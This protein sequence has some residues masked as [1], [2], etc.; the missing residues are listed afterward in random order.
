MSILFD[1]ILRESEMLIPV[2]QPWQHI[3]LAQWIIGYLL[4]LITVIGILFFLKHMYHKR[5]SRMKDLQNRSA[6]PLRPKG[7]QTQES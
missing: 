6:T 7:F 4:P 1:P 2:S 3:N 5:S